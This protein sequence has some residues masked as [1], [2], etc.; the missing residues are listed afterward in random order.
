M[1]YS[2]LLVGLYFCLWKYDREMIF[3]GQPIVKHV[4]AIIPITSTLAS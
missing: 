3:N 2:T 4:R 1:I